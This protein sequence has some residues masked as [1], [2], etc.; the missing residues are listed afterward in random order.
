MEV[1]LGEVAWIS[2][3]VVVYEVRKLYPS[4]QMIYWLLGCFRIVKLTVKLNLTQSLQ[5]DQGTANI[6]TVVICDNVYAFFRILVGLVASYLCLVNSDHLLK[7]RVDDGHVRLGL[8]LVLLGRHL[9]DDLVLD[10]SHLL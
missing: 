4:E 1:N 7:W 10:F 3:S 8:V 2:A 6:E 9:R 5:I